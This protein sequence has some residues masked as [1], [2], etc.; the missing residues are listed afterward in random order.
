MAIPPTGRTKSTAGS[1]GDTR[2]LSKQGKFPDCLPGVGFLYWPLLRLSAPTP[3]S[4]RLAGLLFAARQRQYADDASKNSNRVSPGSGVDAKKQQSLAAF[5][6]RA[7]TFCAEFRAGSTRPGCGV[8]YSA[9]RHRSRGRVRSGLRA[10]GAGPHGEG[11]RRRG[12]VSPD[13]VP[14]ATENG[15]NG[16]G[17]QGDRGPRLAAGLAKAV[18]V[19]HGLAEVTAAGGPSR[20][21]QRAR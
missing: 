1:V 12:R 14:A 13:L 9:L 20:C 15:G 2:R 4:L 16:G 7:C 10:S 6:G 21:R 18:A 17:T 11:L 8:Q 19:Q 3:Y 5:D